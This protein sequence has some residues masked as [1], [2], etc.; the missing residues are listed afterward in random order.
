MTSLAAL[1][2]FVAVG[3]LA[4]ILSYIAMRGIG[5]LN[6]RFLFDTPRPVGEGGKMLH[7]QDD[8]GVDKNSRNNRRNAS[9]GVN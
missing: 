6:F 9:Q 5:A 8:D 3:I 2:T 1:C 4:V 7:G